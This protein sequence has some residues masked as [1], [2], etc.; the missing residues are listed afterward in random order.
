MLL[1]R[2]SLPAAVLLLPV[3]ATENGIHYLNL[4]ATGSVL[5][6]GSVSE[7]SQVTGV[8]LSSLSTL[9]SPQQLV[10]LVGD[11]GEDDAIARSP[12][13]AERKTKMGSIEQLAVELEEEIISRQ[14]S[15]AN[16]PLII[17]FSL[18]SDQG[19]EELSRLETAV[20]RG[21][22]HGIFTI[23]VRQQPVDITNTFGAR[24]SFDSSD[25]D[26]DELALTIGRDTSIILKPVEVRAQPLRR[27]AEPPEWMAA[28][29][30]ASLSEPPSELADSADFA[31]EPAKVSEDVQLDDGP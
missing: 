24:V 7:P 5:L 18:L 30:V 19:T 3:G 27:H 28:E 10:F 8:W 13:F 15:A 2:A 17:A 22:E 12:A 25:T 9:H 11:C 21:P 1:D 23:C 26:Q 6:T 29:A 4:A 31:I 16:P 14:S 20:H